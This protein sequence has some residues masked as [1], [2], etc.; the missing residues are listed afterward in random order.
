MAAAKR[1]RMSSGRGGA[2]FVRRNKQGEFSEVESVGRSLKQDRARKAKNSTT[3]GQGDK[4]DRKVSSSRGSRGR[5]SNGGRKSTSRGNGRSSARGR[6]SGG[7]TTASRSTTKRG[8]S[9]RGG[10]R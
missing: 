8:G 5:T 9:K 7:R 3:P 4:G 6:S 2:R 1:E 10:G